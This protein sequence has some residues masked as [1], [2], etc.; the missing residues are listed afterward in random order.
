MGGRGGEARHGPV[1]AVAALLE[2]CKH[3]SQV[4]AAPPSGHDTGMH[5]EYEVQVFGHDD[6]V[7]HLDHGV[8]ATDGGGEFLSYHLS[9]GCQFHMGCIG[10]RVIRLVIAAR[11]SAQWL[12]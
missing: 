5:L 8:V 1:A 9:Y 11:H 2:A 3:L 12:E 7:L 4:I 10:C 6:I